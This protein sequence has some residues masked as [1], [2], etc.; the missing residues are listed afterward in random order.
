M[1]I[2]S[3]TIESIKY[4]GIVDVNNFLYDDEVD[5]KKLNDEIKL[6]YKVVAKYLFD[7]A[8]GVANEL[9]LDKSKTF[10]NLNYHWSK[11]TLYNDNDDSIV[12]YVS[13]NK[14]DVDRLEIYINDNGGVHVQNKIIMN[15]ARF[16]GTII[17]G[18]DAFKV[19]C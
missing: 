13:D 3:N 10:V 7:V 15:N 4:Y 16:T 1:N 19:G 9:N 17:K 8:E 18:T 12:I 2:F 14:T 6:G 11:V 5:V